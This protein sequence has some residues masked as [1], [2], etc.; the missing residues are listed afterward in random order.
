MPRHLR[1][2]VDCNLNCDGLAT[3]VDDDVI[4]NRCSIKH[5]IG[6]SEVLIN[7]ECLDE[8]SYIKFLP[9]AELGTRMTFNNNLTYVKSEKDGRKYCS[10]NRKN[11]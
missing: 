6:E 8:I 3:T 2:R 1:N 10:T 11:G 5:H 9:D 7:L 4:L